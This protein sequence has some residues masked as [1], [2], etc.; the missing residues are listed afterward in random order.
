[1]FLLLQSY[2]YSDQPCLQADGTVTPEQPPAVKAFDFLPKHIQ[3]EK[4][5]ASAPE[6][7]F[8]LPTY[9]NIGTS[10]S[11]QAEEIPEATTDMNPEMDEV[12]PSAFKTKADNHEWI[13]WWQVVQSIKCNGW[14]LH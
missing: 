13:F 9:F 10:S 8:H 7:H 14:I 1:M 6:I 12:P 3:K 4:K 2:F 5:A 11:I